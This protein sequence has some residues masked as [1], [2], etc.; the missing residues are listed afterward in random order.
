MDALIRLQIARGFSAPPGAWV[1]DPRHGNKDLEPE[2]AMN[3]QLGSE[4]RPFPFLKLQAGVFRADIHDF[5]N[6]SYAHYR[7]E[8]ISDVT[9]QGFEANAVA[10]IG[11]SLSVAF[12]GTYTDVRNDRTGETVKDVPRTL[13]NASVSYVWKQ[14]TQS[15]VGRY[16]DDN[17]SYPETHDKVFV[18]DYLF[19]FR[20]PVPQLAGKDPV[21]LFAAV[22]DL[23]DA[24]YL[25]RYSFPQP[26]RRVEGGVSFQF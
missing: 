15:I 3:Y 12:G 25:H 13:L 17:S 14:T 19:K 6:F 23:T 10:S 18:F 26:G 5:I 4:F 24:G 2:T 9:R 20:L 7:F 22:Y 11:P 21:T 8:N 16:V 1:N